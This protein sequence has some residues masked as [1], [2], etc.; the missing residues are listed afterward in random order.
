MLAARAAHGGELLVTQAGIAATLVFAAHAGSTDAALARVADALIGA[1]SA[2]LVSLLVLPPHP[3]ELLKA[4]VDPLLAELADVLERVASALRTGDG[5]QATAALD[6]ARAMS[7]L[8]DALHAARPV[9]VEVARFV[10]ARRGS[11]ELATRMDS[12]SV[13]LDHA[14]RN[15][16]VLARS[17]LALLPAE[18]AVRDECASAAA[19]LAE[20]VRHLD[21]SSDANIAGV[22]LARYAADRLAAIHAHNSSAALGAVA[23]TSRGIADDLGLVSSS[24]SRRSA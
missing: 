6:R 8:V 20:A 13:H 14:V 10:P 24:R 4:R 18:Q 19:T 9:A 11:R 21:P 3:I 7:D 12:A 16:R 2:G 22:E 23:T 17:A 1:A 15:A 5:D